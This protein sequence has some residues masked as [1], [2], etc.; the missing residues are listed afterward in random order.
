MLSS[1]RRLGRPH[2]S[3]IETTD[4]PDRPIYQYPIK[5]TDSHSQE[6]ESII[7]Q[8]SKSINQKDTVVSH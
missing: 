2:Q 8:E 5:A 3:P 1:I 4:S 7:S 6:N